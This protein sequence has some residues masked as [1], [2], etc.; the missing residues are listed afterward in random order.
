VLIPFSGAML[1]L[2]L[3][4]LDQ[5]IV[6]TALPRIVGDLHGLNHLSWVVTAYLLTSTVTVPLYGKLS[7]LYG[8]KRLF[9]VAIPLFLA[10]S[11]LCGAAQSMDQ[12]IAFRALQGIGAGGLI[13]LTFAVIGDLFSPRERGRYQGLT[14]AVWGVAAVAGP[15]LGGVLTDSVSWRWIFYVN[16][17]LGGLA[18]VVIATTMHIPFEPHGHAIDYAGSALLTL[19]AVSL[20]L[21]AVWG[22]Q[23][24]AWTSAEI[25]GLLAAGA[26]L[27]VA[28]V[29]VEL[30]VPEP[31][32]PLTLFR[33]SIFTV[34]NTAALVIGAALFGALIYIPLFV[35]GV[36]GGSA[37]NSGVVLIPLSFGWVATSVV[38]GQ[39]ISRTG[40]YRP[41]PIA[42]SILLVI[43][44]WLLTRVDSHTSSLTATGDMLVIGLGLGLMYQT[45]VL[46]V[47]NAVP[48]RQ[49]GIATASVQFF[50]SIGATF[51]V[52][53]LGSVLTARLHT[54]LAARLGSAAKTVDPQVLLQSPAS[55]AR[56][57]ASLVD[58]VRAALA[59]SL[60]S[61]FD[62]CLPLALATVVTGLLLR[63]IPLRAKAGVEAHA[64]DGA[65]SLGPGLAAADRD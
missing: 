33:N 62:L 45:Y 15:L 64:D 9:L 16:L 2:L 22:G 49:L 46:A 61:V 12:L 57:P 58:G 60:H 6:A 30:R 21:A 32:L 55:V 13:P 26:L 1:G 50:R 10:G 17:P 29:A 40:R 41:F 25:V 28:F 24:Y 59:V 43:G 52:A 65:P 20:L 7:D 36:I 31:I 14:G 23:N 8:R 38:S 11:A 54:E 34:A 56:L 42:G 44:F 51:A 35:Q 5:T 19:G 27:L 39:L 37:T 47:Q 3:A 18:L 63:E 53:A 48:P 4:A